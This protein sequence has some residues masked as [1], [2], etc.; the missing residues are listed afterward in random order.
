MDKKP[1]NLK[2]DEIL[3]LY[4][5]MMKKYKLKFSEEEK[6][7]IEKMDKDMK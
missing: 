5:V 3:Q 7:V 4:E 6:K 1:Q 2:S